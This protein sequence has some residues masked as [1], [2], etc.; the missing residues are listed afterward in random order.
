MVAPPPAADQPRSS[1]GEDP[2]LGMHYKYIREVPTT[3]TVTVTAEGHGHPVSPEQ[4][5]D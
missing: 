2:Y 1:L 4:R 3:L 5:V